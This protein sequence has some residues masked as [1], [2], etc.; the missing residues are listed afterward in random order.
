MTVNRIV[1]KGMG[2][3]QSTGLVVLGF[4]IDI[5]RVIRGGRSVAR[6]L[7]K[8]LYE[9]FLIAAKLIEI[10]GKELFS[11]IF[12]RRKYVIDESKNI[13][14]KAVRKYFQVPELERSLRGQLLASKKI[15]NYYGRPLETTA[16]E[17][18]VLVSHFIQSTAVDV[19]L[20]GF[21][22]IIQKAQIKNINPI[23]LIHDAILYLVALL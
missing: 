2:G 23:F 15:S 12:N 13:V 22:Q 17:P 21:S 4:T 19:A 1:T 7:Y 11:P 16:F 18:H 3:G 5:T 10:N 6:D 20:A 14:V 8:N 9:E